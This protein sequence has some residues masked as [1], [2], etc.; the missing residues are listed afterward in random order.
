MKRLWILGASDPEMA[1]VERL[2]TDAGETVAHAAFEFARV[3]PGNAYRASGYV[4]DGYPGTSWSGDVVFVECDIP[5]FRVVDCESVTRIDH[6]RPGD[7]G[8][9]L[10]PERYW[11]ASSLGQVCRL[12][13]S[14]F[15]IGS[16]PGDS[17]YDGV[18]HITTWQSQTDLSDFECVYVCDAHL[19]AAADHCLSHAYRG[20]CPGVDPDA[21]MGWRIRSRAEFQGRPVAEVLSDIE[22]A[23]AS[24]RVAKL[25]DLR[26][27]ATCDSVGRVPGDEY[28]C[29]ADCCGY[30]THVCPDCDGSASELCR[31]MRGQHIPELPEASAREGICFIA[32]GLPGPDG[33]IKIVCQSGTPDEIR[34]FMAQWAPPNGLTDI[35]GDP[36]RGFAGGYLPGP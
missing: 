10:P 14:E 2:L 9:G 8:Y 22:L 12:L 35:Y 26:P 4:I 34:A 5:D 23:M 15:G 13:G 20:E 1:A 19:I 24:L 25:I 28:P 33:R 7:P 27:C 30:E 29:G 16:E 18:I 6:H 21:L 17:D 31:D 36:Q 32:D 3:H 11:E